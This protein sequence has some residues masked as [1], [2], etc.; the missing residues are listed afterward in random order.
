MVLTFPEK[1]LPRYPGVILVADGLPGQVRIAS[2]R[3]S[4]C[5]PITFS[6]VVDVGAMGTRFAR[7]GAGSLS[8][9][10]KSRCGMD[11]FDDVKIN[12]A[13]H[14]CLDRCYRTDD[15]LPVIAEFLKEL[16]AADD[17][18]KSEIVEVELAVHKVLHA[19]IVAGEPSADDILHGR[20]ATTMS[21]S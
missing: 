7:H 16:G 6:A 19:V 9:R 2:H 17:W 4:I 3:H 8:I 13:V 1:L 14:E 18:K 21:D 5:I 15:F 10:Y 12:N 20:N 11:E